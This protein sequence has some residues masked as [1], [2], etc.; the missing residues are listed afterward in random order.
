M[1]LWGEVNKSRSGTLFS[2]I[3]GEILVLGQLYVFFFFL[4]IT[5]LGELEVGEYRWA[6]DWTRAERSVLS[7]FLYGVFSWT[8]SSDSIWYIVIGIIMLLS[9]MRSLKLR[10]KKG[11][12]RGEFGQKLLMDSSVSQSFFLRG[13]SLYEHCAPLCKP[14]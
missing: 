11:S 14:L 9:V 2:G 1:V 5:L 6:E 4:Y 3:V 10:G 12:R 7:G 13:A 8:C